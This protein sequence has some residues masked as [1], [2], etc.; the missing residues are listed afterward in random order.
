MRRCST[1]L[2]VVLEFD[3]M[4][5]LRRNTLLMMFMVATSVLAIVFK[6]VH[7]ISADSLAV[8]FEAMIPKQFG[9]WHEVTQ[10]TAQ[11]INPQQ[12]E[13]LDKIYTQTLSRTYIN[14]SGQSIMLSIAYGADQSRENQVH[15]P[16]V[17]YPAQGFQLHGTQKDFIRS[18]TG[19]IPVMRLHTS[20]GLRV[21]PVTYWIRI[22]D[23]VSRGAIEQNLTRLQYGMRG[24]I[25]DGLL[26][27][28][29]SINV[30]P[31][32]AYK[33]HD[34]FVKDLLVN[35]SPAIRSQL[36]GSLVGLA[37]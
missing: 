22:G 18:T 36:I 19:A 13:V 23:K 20:L 34:I 31:E 35:V 9:E 32:S 1:L 5:S 21:E 27:R 29:S 25:P 26:F 7:R 37:H 30:D 12:K 2:N 15:K 17:C 33:L 6:P 11:I 8:N 10:Q 28:V 24:Y 14:T 16:E 4:N 3:A